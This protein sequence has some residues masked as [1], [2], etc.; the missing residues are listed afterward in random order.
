MKKTIML[1]LAV[2]ASPALAQQTFVSV[3]GGLAP[4][5]VSVKAGLENPE[6]GFGARAGIKLRPSS[7]G[8]FT[9]LGEATYNT[10]IA[11]NLNG[12]VGAGVQYTRDTTTSGTF[13]PRASVGVDYAA[14]R[15]ASV[16]VEGDA[17]YALNSGATNR[18]SFGV[19][20]GVKFRF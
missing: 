8:N 5:T 18:W 19:G 6:G 20:A 10:P 4:F 13:A 1:S 16:F 12:V 7:L 17:A 15:N 3:G 11:T 9:V 14:S 2:L